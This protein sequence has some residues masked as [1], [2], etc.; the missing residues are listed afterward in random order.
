MPNRKEH[1]EAGGWTGAVAL[2][3]LNVAVQA[4]R[5]QVDPNYQFNVL[6]LAAVSAAGYGAGS[7]GAQVPDLLEPAYHPGHRN[8]FHSVAFGTLAAVAVKKLN[9]NPAVPEGIKLAANAGTIGFVSHLV[10][11]GNTPAGIPLIF[12]S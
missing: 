10:M 3:L 6:E 4:Q 8:F 11:D 5:K 9:D 7:L 1:A 2:G 12:R